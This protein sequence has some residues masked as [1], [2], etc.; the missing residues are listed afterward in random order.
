[1]RFSLDDLVE[2]TGMNGRSKS[3]VSPLCQEIVRN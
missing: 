3:E 1:M 2:A